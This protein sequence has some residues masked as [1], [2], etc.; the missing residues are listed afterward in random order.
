MIFFLATES[1][2]R[3]WEGEA[4][5]IGRVHSLHTKNSWQQCDAL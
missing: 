4:S 1:F 5:C 3:I 2:K